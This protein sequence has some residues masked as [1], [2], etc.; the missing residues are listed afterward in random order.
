MR[1]LLKRTFVFCVLGK[2]TQEGGVRGVLEAKCSG[3]SKSYLRVVQVN[4]TI[5]WLFLLSG[6]KPRDS[7]G[8]TWVLPCQRSGKKQGPLP[9]PNPSYAVAEPQ[10]LW[11]LPFHWHSPL[12]ALLPVI[13]GWPSC[14]WQQAAKL[15]LPLIIP[16]HSALRAIFS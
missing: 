2:G 1:E 7:Q 6:L 14:C 12:A 11:V 10:F 3:K 8:H 9:S 15:H 16:L 13:T 4:T 5:H